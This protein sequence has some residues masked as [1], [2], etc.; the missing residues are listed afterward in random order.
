MDIGEEGDFLFETFL[1]AAHSLVCSCLPSASA[2]ELAIYVRNFVWTST[3]P[4]LTALAT[5]RV[6]K[7]LSSLWPD[8]IAR[9]WADTLSPSS[10]VPWRKRGR[11][12]SST[13]SWTTQAHLTY[14][15]LVCQAMGGKVSFANDRLQS[16]RGSGRAETGNIRSFHQ[17]DPVDDGL[18]RCSTAEV[19]IAMRGA[20]KKQ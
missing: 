4:F 6:Y 11:P 14:R 13:C 1:F 16:K 5:I 3:S 20:F 9:T 15:Q 2:V 19:R 12:H 18:G 7:S 8:F 10:T 17:Q